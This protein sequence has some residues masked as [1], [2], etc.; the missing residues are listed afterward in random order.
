M[1]KLKQ[2]ILGA[3]IMINLSQKTIQ[4]QV[5]CKS[6][7]LHS[8]K[9][10]KM[11]LIPGEIDSGIIF[12]RR[13]LENGKNEILA[14]Y[15]NVITTNLGT[16]IAN[17]FGSEVLTIEHL[18]AAIWGSGIDNLIVELDGKEIPIMDGSSKPFIFLIECAGIKQQEK[19]R[20]VIEILKEIRVEDGDKF[21]EVKPSKDFSL[22]L[23][24][25][26]KNEKIGIQKF[27]YHHNLNSFKNDVSAARTFCLKEEIEQMHKMNLAKGGTLNNAIVVDGANIV[28]ES[29]LRFENEFVRHKILDFIGDIYLAGNY[30]IGSFN[31]HKTGH[32][33]NNKILKEIFSNP[34]NYR[35]V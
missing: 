23:E 18:M 25:E 28:N 19:N 21:V 7:G 3:K 9:E 5:S 24:I 12:R 17:E 4:S 14:N 27:S 35:L 32:G 31:A 15:K 29:P 30:I 16:T 6:L 13:D 22:D 26:F 11:T 20:Q 2:N 1:A 10:V 33:L 8:G 34:E